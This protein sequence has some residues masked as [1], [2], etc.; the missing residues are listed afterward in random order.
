MPHHTHC[1]VC[2]AAATYLLA[3]PATGT[4]PYSVGGS[5]LVL[6][7]DWRDFPLREYQR[8]WAFLSGTLLPLY[9]VRT[10]RPSVCRGTEALR[11]VSLLSCYDHHHLPAA[12]APAMLYACLTPL[13]LGW[14]LLYIAM[15]GGAGILGCVVAHLQQLG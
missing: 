11:L 14:S 10:V 2:C 3:A 4:P 12:A 7:A 15:C 9:V 6:R 13:Q 5:V 1:P 8:W